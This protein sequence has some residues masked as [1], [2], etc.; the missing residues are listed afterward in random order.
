MKKSV[1]VISLFVLMSLLIT[2][3]SFGQVGFGKGIKAGLV[4]SK[5]TGDDV[6]DNADRRSGFAAGAFINFG[7]SPLPLSIQVE[8]LYVMK[9]ADEEDVEEEITFN[10]ELKFTYLEIPVLAKLTVVAVPGLKLQVFGGPSLGILLSAKSKLTVGNESAE[11]DI[12]DDVKSTDLGLVLGVALGISKIHFDVR[13]IM[14][15][16][17]IDEVDEDDVKN[18]VLMATAGISL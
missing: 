14:S 3:V 1:P 8:A 11:I 10:T 6:N 4:S 13:Y 12:K 2:S 15:M 5:L 16:S 18:S 17:T 7:L 9:G